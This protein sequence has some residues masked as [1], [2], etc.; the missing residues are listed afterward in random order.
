MQTPD[1]SDT[2]ALLTGH[3]TLSHWL[4]TTSQEGR[5]DKTFQSVCKFCLCED[6]PVPAGRKEKKRLSWRELEHKHESTKLQTK[7]NPFF[8]FFRN[9]PPS[10]QTIIYSTHPRR[11]LLSKSNQL[12]L[13]ITNHQITKEFLL[14]IFDD[15]GFPLDR[16]QR[17]GRFSKLRKVLKWYLSQ[18][19]L[20]CRQT[21][22]P[23]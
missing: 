5:W 21:I 18:T 2:S 23:N 12:H 13:K 15:A 19:L 6:P 16:H 17:S 1:V 10:F 11:V 20:L 4:R 9:L 8:S 3:F 7:P 14:R 22:D